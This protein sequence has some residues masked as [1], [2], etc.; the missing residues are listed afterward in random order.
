MIRPSEWEIQ[1]KNE[2]GTM[3][4]VRGFNSEA[5]AGDWLTYNVAE[6]GQQYPAALVTVVPIV[7][8]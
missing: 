1:I 5:A 6:L 4:I 3:L 8:R 7:H 2:R